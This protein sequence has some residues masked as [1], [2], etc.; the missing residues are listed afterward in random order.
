[1]ASCPFCLGDVPE[2]ARKCQHCGE[3]L[4]ARPRPQGLAGF[5][6]SDDLDDTLNAGLQTY[7][8]F[9]IVMS[10]IGFAVFLI[11]LFGVVL[12]SFS[13]GGF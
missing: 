13:R 8:K 6:K 5:F 2:G 11:I 9:R 4:T 3:W 7:V 10:A 1:M 12:P